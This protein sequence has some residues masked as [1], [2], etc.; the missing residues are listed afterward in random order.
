MAKRPTADWRSEVAVQAA[1]VASGELDPD[2]AWAADLWPEGLIVETDVALD[3]FEAV[4][5]SLEVTN[6]TAVFDAIRHVVLI[7]N[8]VSAR[9]YPGFETG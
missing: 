6:D 5:T 3:E 8:A 7:L 4:L 9:N 2:K 1:G